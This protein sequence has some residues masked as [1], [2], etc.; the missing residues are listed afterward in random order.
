MQIEKALEI[1]E[2][3]ENELSGRRWSRKKIHD[4]IGAQLNSTQPSYSSLLED[5]LAYLYRYQ[6]VILHKKSK[7]IS[8]VPSD[9]RLWQSELPIWFGDDEGCWIYE[10]TVSQD[11]L[12]WITEKEDAH[13]KIQW[14]TADGKLEELKSEVLK[15]NLIAHAPPGSDAKVKKDDW[16]RTLGRSQAIETLARGKV[17]IQ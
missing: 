11:L 16:A 7:S 1:Q 8:F 3:V 10:P 15:R 13:W 9:L 17:R 4:E 5:V 6:K 14:P 2:R 12:R